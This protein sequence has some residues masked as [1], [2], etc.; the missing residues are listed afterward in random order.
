MADANYV[1]IQI[2]ASDTA[3]PDLTS[4]K[5]QLDELGAKAE[6]AKVSVDDT[7]STAKLLAINAQLA[8]LNAKT[9]KPNITIAG[10]AKAEADIAAVELKLDKLGTDSAT[11][12]SKVGGLGSRL[13]A[14][15]GAVGAVTGV[16]DAMTLASGDASMFQR[17]MAGAS[18]ATGLLEPALA[19]VVVAAGG[20]A[21]GVTAAGVGLAAFGLVAKANY[22][23]AATAA[24]QV[25]TAQDTYNAS[26][27]AGVAPAKAYQAEQKAI[28][29][30]YAELSPA[31]IQLSKEIGNVSNAWQSFVQSNTA[32]VSKILT[33]GFGLI[34]KIFQTIQPLMAPVE[35][36]LSHIISQL[37]TGLNSSGFK[38]FMDSLTQ[39]TGPAIEKIATAIGHVVEGIGGILKAFMPVSQGLL[40]G[41]DQLTAKFA[42]WGETLSSHSGFQSLMETFKSETPLVV[43]VLKNLAE[44][45]KNVASAMTGLATG[46]NSKA[47]LQILLALSGAIVPL[48]KNTDLLRVALY[49]LAAVDVGKNIASMFTS[50]SNGLQTI[51]GG[52]NI[53]GKFGAAA[54]DASNME[55]LAAAATKVWTGDSG[56]VRR[57]DGRQPDR[58]GRHR[59][60]RPGRRDHLRLHA[61]PDVPHDRQRRR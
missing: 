43:A 61:F 52:I 15:G 1:Q 58:A 14:L 37:S 16:G 39:N 8:S 48:T 6:T 26:I 49:V 27:K 28:A 20:L 31:Q 9:A 47:L 21:A 51:Q 12:D 22:T 23:T 24:K 59:Y 7:D 29:L 11:A 40:S 57:G 60:R 42:A 56:R 19:G 2:K 25:Q 3:K 38:S 36:A 41:L 10:A 4:L 50:V 17:V 34:P 46:S 18:L 44:I 53:L 13:M 30:A 5:A 32:G 45:L 33:Q 54:Q 55:K 35:A